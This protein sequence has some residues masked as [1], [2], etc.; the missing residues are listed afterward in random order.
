MLLSFWLWA[1]QHGGLLL[2][3]PNTLGPAAEMSQHLPEGEAILKQSDGP[4]ASRLCPVWVLPSA[5]LEQT[6]GPNNVC[7][8]L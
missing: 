1:E 3:F 6:G 4:E 7:W 2:S 5:S 8:M